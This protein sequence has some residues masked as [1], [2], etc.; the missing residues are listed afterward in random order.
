MGLQNLYNLT[1]RPWEPAIFSGLV[2]AFAAANTT[3]P[4]CA[5][6]QIDTVV[7]ARSA[8]D[9]VLD[10]VSSASGSIKPTKDLDSLQRM[11]VNPAAGYSM[12]GAGSSIGSDLTQTPLVF[13]TTAGAPTTSSLAFILVDETNKEQYWQSSAVQTGEGDPTMRINDPITAMADDREEQEHQ[14]VALAAAT[15]I[16]HQRNRAAIL[17]GHRPDA[18][19]LRQD[20]LRGQCRSLA[21][22][23]YGHDRVARHWS[24]LSPLGRLER[25]QPSR[26]FGAH[27]PESAPSSST[28]AIPDASPASTPTATK[29]AQKES[30]LGANA[31]PALQLSLP[32][33]RVIRSR[34]CA[35]SFSPSF[36]DLQRGKV[37]VWK[38]DLEIKGRGG[39]IF[40]VLVVG[41]EA[42]EYL[43]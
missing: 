13:P 7:A 16:Q 15:S 10:D 11:N 9:A 35:C 25:V 23:R 14:L 6:S 21:D 33:A 3:K 22:A 30:E 17:T 39:G 32:E 38:G 36:H 28:P 20:G 27:T 37:G 2:A 1:L 40:S 5:S 29:V 42:T 19:S 18:A 26:L 34:Q 43:W 41:E 12:I 4:S 24:A 8:L 31:R